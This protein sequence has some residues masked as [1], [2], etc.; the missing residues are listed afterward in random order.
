[1][2]VRRAMYELKFDKI[3]RAKLY[4]N[5]IRKDLPDY[6]IPPELNEVFK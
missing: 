5:K 6:Q 4:I 3:E 1:M 2:L